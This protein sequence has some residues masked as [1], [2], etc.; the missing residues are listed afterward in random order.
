MANILLKTNIA[1][2][3]GEEQVQFLFESSYDL[4]R[5]LNEV[6]ENVPRVARAFPYS[7]EQYDTSMITYVEDNILV[8]QFR[9]H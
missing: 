9:Y 8:L 2:I 3:E 5:F 7:C 1:L 6:E 4:N